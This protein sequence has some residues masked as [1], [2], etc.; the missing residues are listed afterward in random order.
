M[1]IKISPE[2][3]SI[4]RAILEVFRGTPNVWSYL[5]ENEK[6][7]VDIL[8]CEDVPAK[9]ITSYSTIGLSDFSIDLRS[10]ETPL[11][12]ELVGA[13]RTGYE[14][15]PNILATCAFNIINSG[16]KC[17]PG[18]IFQHI[19]EMYYPGIEMKHILF[20]P[21]FGWRREFTTLEFATKKVTWLC[22]VP[23]SDEENA[24]AAEKGVDALE[25]LFE[26]KQTN[27]H[28]L[29]RRSEHTILGQ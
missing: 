23:I 19:V 6:S 2:N 9:S 13:C 1:S 21:T 11:G 18:A 4:A 16:Y 29:G 14:A 26:E 5:D 20:I 12:L 10:G 22:V 3:Q 8:S 27:I 17:R 25:S 24:Y 7:K 15:F 28:D